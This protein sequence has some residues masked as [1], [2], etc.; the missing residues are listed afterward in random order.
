MD[1]YRDVLI[2]NIYK[3][4]FRPKTID[5]LNKIELGPSERIIRPF[6][7]NYVPPVQPDRFKDAFA[8]YNRLAALNVKKNPWYK[9]VIKNRWDKFRYDLHLKLIEWK[10]II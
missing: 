4:N 3:S 1:V 10:V 5:D 6:I 8:K 2:E 9:P 7:S